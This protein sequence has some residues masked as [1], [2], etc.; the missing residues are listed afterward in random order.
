MLQYFMTSGENLLGINA[1]L[2]WLTL[3]LSKDR[4]SIM[5]LTVI[6]Q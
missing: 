4:N 3:Y 2:K 5:G 1:L 6:A